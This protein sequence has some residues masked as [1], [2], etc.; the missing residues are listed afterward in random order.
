MQ[1]SSEYLIVTLCRL[2]KQIVAVVALLPMVGLFLWTQDSKPSQPLKA[3]PTPNSQ[4]VQNTLPPIQ[5]DGSEV[6]HHLNQLISW[7][8]HSTTGIQPVGLP[9]DAIYQDN[10]RSLGSQAVRLAFESAK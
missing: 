10:V 2:G 6:L 4:S 7:Y 9:S 1:K 5:L 3:N 8:R